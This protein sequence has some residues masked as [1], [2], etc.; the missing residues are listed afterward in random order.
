MG[1]EVIGFLASPALYVQ[2]KGQTGHGR[3]STD[4]LKWSPICSLTST[5]LLAFPFLDDL[6]QLFVNGEPSQNFPKAIIPHAVESSLKVYE[7]EEEITFVSQ[8]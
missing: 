8:C 1:I 2:G 5:A 6:R 4:V 7:V 3:M